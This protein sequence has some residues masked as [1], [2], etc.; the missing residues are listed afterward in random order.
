[1]ERGGALDVHDPRCV[2]QILRQLG[3]RPGSG[4]VIVYP[5]DGEVSLCSAADERLE[6]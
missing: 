5:L 1:V 3:A 6:T 2:Q 4:V